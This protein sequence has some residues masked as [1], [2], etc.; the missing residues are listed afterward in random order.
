MPL[1]DVE[2]KLNFPVPGDAALEPPAEWERLRRQRAVAH[3]SLSGADDASSLRRYEDVEAVLSG[4]RF[5]RELSGCGERISVYGTG[6]VSKSPMADLLPRSGEPHQRR[7]RMAG[8]WSAVKR[9][10]ALRPGIGPMADRPVGELREGGK[11]AG[12]AVGGLRELPVRW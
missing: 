6:G 3:V 2:S 4:P 10:S 5:T 8:T 7:R 12:L 9:V 11:P 1:N